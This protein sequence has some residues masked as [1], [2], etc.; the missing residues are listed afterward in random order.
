MS[1]V[2]VRFHA[3][4]VHHACMHNEE[5]TARLTARSVHRAKSLALDWEQMATRMKLLAQGLLKHWRNTTK[6]EN[7]HTHEAGWTGTQKTL[8]PAGDIHPH[9]KIGRG[10]I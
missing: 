10:H 3:T 8:S 1:R 2:L 5:G 9:K 4:F 7:P 6:I